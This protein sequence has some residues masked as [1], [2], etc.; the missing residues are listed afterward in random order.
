MVV[1]SRDL[2]VDREVLLLGRVSRGAGSWEE[3]TGRLRWF[4]RKR[5][6]HDAFTSRSF[7]FMLLLFL[8]VMLNMLDALTTV[9]GTSRL[10]WGAEANPIMRWV[11]A[12]WG[13]WGFMVYKSMG[14]GLVTTSLWLMHRGF[15]RAARAAR[16][17]RGRWTF[18]FWRLFLEVVTL[19]LVALF[20]YVVW[21]NLVI[22]VAL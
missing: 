9:A 6:H 12:Q 7:G 1:R 15:S 8:F 5:P 10:G 14:V 20:T 17:A 3:R 4:T 18:S 22:V 2:L 11:G 19:G 13:A 16:G 21:S